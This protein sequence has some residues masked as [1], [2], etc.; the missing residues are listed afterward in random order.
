MN[1][2][3]DDIVEEVIT[4]YGGIANTQS[5]FKYKDPMAVYNWRSR[6]IPRALIPNIHIDTGICLNRLMSSTGKSRQKSA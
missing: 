1:N 2:Q 3:I 6:G 5:R 4:A